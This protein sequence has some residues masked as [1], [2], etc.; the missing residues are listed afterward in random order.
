[1]VPRV[2]PRFV[3]FEDGRL[4]CY[5]MGGLGFYSF[6]DLN[7]GKLLFFYKIPGYNEFTL[8]NNV[9]M[10]NMLCLARSFR[11]Q[12]VDVVVK[13]TDDEFTRIQS[14]SQ[15]VNGTDSPVRCSGF[16]NFDIDDEVDLLETFCPH[17][18]K[19]FILESWARG[20][21][22]IGQQ[23]GG[24]VIEF[25]NV[26]RKYVVQCDFQFN[27]V[28]NDSVRITAICAMSATKGCK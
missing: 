16:D 2:I 1:M 28:K 10:D 5:E 9:D 11:L 14:H 23:F 15:P 24:G 19:V 17:N 18:D 7:P 21:T 3:G 6:K 12:I 22:H 25:R 27:Y 20:F 4:H 8:Q 26:L 13:Q